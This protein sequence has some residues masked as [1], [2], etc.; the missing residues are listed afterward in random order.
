MKLYYSNVR[1][2]YIWWL[3]V[4]IL[5]RFN[6]DITLVQ[7]DLSKTISRCKSNG[8]TARNSIA[9]QSHLICPLDVLSSI[10]HPVIYHFF[11]ISF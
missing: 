5:K 7:I 6:H 3:W 8:E 10:P 9:Y 2:T 4:D 11:I 1:N